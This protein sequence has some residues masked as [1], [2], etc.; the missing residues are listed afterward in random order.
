MLRWTLSLLALVLPAPLAAG[1]APTPSAHPTTESVALA[2]PV[3]NSVIT[4]SVRTNKATAAAP[5]F[6]APSLDAVM[7][8]EPALRMP[9]PKALLIAPR[10]CAGVKQ[11]FNVLIH[12]HGAYSTVEPILMQSGIDGVYVVMNLG[13]GSG[14][15]EDAFAAPGSLTSYLGMIEQRINQRCGSSER[16]VDRVALSGWS[17]GYGAIIKALS[18]PK[19]AAR[20]DTV[21]LSDGLHVGFEPGRGRHVRALAMEPFQKFAASAARGE[22]MMAITHS[23]IIPP[24]Y[25]ST[26]ETAKFLA[27]SLDVATLPVDENGPLPEMRRISHAERG[28]LTIDGFAGMDARAH[29]KQLYAIGDTLWS[30]LAARWSKR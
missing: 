8:S 4:A 30:R 9:L 2:A 26:T 27:D 1:L 6:E 23:A 5:A 29:C 22:T 24:T 15:Y 3:S 12:F 16:N 21:L 10:G 7:P 17:A 11:K 14:A 13:I 25:A 18:R 28:N 20:I 19:E